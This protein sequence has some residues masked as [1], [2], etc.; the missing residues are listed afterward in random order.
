MS[1][2]LM[3]QRDPVLPILI[4]NSDNVSHSWLHTHTCSHTILTLMHNLKFTYHIHTHTVTHIHLVS[5][6]LTV[7]THSHIALLFT[8]RIL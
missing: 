5:H 6:T 4:P 7:Y 1:L 3:S 2:G 8:H